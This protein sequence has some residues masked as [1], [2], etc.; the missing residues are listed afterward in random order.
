M[1]EYSNKMMDHF[2][3]PRNVGEMEDPSGTG[4]VGNPTC[5]DIM[6][7]YIK[8]ED[9]VIVDAKFKTFGCGAAIAASS[10]V[11]E[12]IKGRTIARALRVS[13]KDVVASLDGL[14][15]IKMHCSI[16]GV[17]ALQKAIKDYRSKQG[18]SS[19]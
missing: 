3:N 13:D 18:T 6:E 9:E 5:G 2:M 7:M 14:P 11:T 15:A 16:L 19:R 4:K 1:Q 12:L 10:I 8:V 17:E